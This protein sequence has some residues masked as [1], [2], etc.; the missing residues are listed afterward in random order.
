[1]SFL[2]RLVRRLS[3]VAFVAV[4]GFVAFELAYERTDTFR[5][6]NRLYY[7]DGRATTAG[8]IFA[9]FWS[10]VAFLGLVPPVIVS[11]ETVGARS[12]QRRAVPMVLGHHAGAEYLVA[13][14]G[15]R[16]AWV[17]NVRAHDGQAW[18]RRGS[19]RE[20]RLVEVPVDER[21]P[22]IKAYLRVA[23]GAR[24]H[25]PVAVDAPLAEFEAIAAAYPVF[26]IEP[27]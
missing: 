10:S 5:R 9:R 8:R 1:M 6:G 2:F 25:I 19:V 13:M 26:R 27:A 12:G 11:L 24:P 14:L 22:V 17:H 23:A 7:R 15:E 16:S 3:F 4:L 20:V 18:L 21:A